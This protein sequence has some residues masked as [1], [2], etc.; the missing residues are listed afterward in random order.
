MFEIITFKFLVFLGSE[1]PTPVGNGF[2]P[3]PTQ[4]VL[5]VSELDRL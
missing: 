2:K 1:L 4:P 5:M 3:F